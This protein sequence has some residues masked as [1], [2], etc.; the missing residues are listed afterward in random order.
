VPGLLIKRA[1]KG[2]LPLIAAA[3][4]IRDE[5]TS[6]AGSAGSRDA[7]S[8]GLADARAVAAG[9][10]KTAVAAIGLA[11]ETHGQAL[12]QQQ[13]VLMALADLLLD[14][15]AVE[16]VVLRAQ[17]AADAKHASAS[18]HADAA[19]VFAHDAGL[20]TEMGAR[21]LLAGLQQGDALRTS[22]AGVRRLLKVPPVDTIAARRRLA[23]A[24]LAARGYPFA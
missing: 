3:K 17:A 2:G 10:K 23:D 12:E 16:T 9:V 5:L 21:T 14:A 13:E 7:A 6:P 1:L 11:L 18:V 24:I 20:R 15:Y 4:A 22:L 19:V 8:S